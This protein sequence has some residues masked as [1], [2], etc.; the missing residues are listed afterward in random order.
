MDPE[1]IDKMINPITGEQQNA[2]V[3]LDSAGL[4]KLVV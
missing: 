1:G 4:Q 3:M 2:A